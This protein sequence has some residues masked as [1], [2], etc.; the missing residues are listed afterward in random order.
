[1][2]TN[3]NKQRLGVVYAGNQPEQEV[4]KL[5]CADLGMGFSEL[6]RLAL[7]EYFQRNQ[8][9]LVNLSDAQLAMLQLPKL[10]HGGH[11]KKA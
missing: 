5:A 2:P 4:V 3:A 1:M 7:A 10:Q 6:T 9:S 8:A 11:N